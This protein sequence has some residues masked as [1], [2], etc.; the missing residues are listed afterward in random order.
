M[1]LVVGQRERPT[2]RS[3][4]DR[5]RR[6][7]L[8]CYVGN[9][10]S[11]SPRPSAPHAGHTMSTNTN[12]AGTGKARP[13][14]RPFHER[15]TEKEGKRRRERRKSLVSSFYALLANSTP[16]NCVNHEE[17]VTNDPAYASPRPVDTVKYARGKKSSSFCCPRHR[18]PQVSHVRSF[19]G[20]K[21]RE[22]LAL[23]VRSSSRRDRGFSKRSPNF[24]LSMD[25]RFVRFR[26]DFKR[27]SFPRNKRPSV[28]EG[29][30]RRGEDYTK[31]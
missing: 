10:T 8:N 29:I 7:Y 21:F 16:R 4:S 12:S 14:T 11:L 15:A 27:C 13:T 18:H 24:T 2:T 25:H 22:W 6:H 23:P 1:V 28:P 20:T 3:S 30:Q 17:S 19:R 31:A 5:R 26:R 9:A